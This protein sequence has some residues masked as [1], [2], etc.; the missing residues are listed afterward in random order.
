MNSTKKTSTSEPPSGL[1]FTTATVT[2]QAAE[3]LIGFACQA[4]TDLEIKVAVAVVDEGGHLKG[5][6][7][8]D[9]MGFLAVDIAINKAW[10]AASFGLPTHVWSNYITD[11]PKVAQLVHHPRLSAVGGGYALLVDGLVVGGIGISGGSYLQDQQVAEIAMKT[12]G[13]EVL[14]EHGSSD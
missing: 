13:F 11:D 8:Q 7:R 14:S 1:A 2:R 10:T 3:K 6:V 5:F 4:A 12:L 9:G